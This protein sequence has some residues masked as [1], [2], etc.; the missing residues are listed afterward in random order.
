MEAVFKVVFFLAVIFF[1]ITIILFFLLGL[2]IILLFTPSN[3]LHVF[4]LTISRTIAEIQAA[5]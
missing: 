1:C 3:E 2:K 4:G 5:Y